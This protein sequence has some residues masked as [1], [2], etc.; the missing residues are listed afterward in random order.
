MELLIIYLV[1]LL[2]T[3]KTISKSLFKVFSAAMGMGMSS[4]YATGILWCERYISITNKIG[5]AFS[6]SGVS[7]QN[8]LQAMIG[9]S[10]FL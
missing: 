6:I 2:K 5:A 10:S 3:L 1:Q 7:L 4:M 8:V 9:Q